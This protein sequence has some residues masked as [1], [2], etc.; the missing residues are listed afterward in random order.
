MNRL[1]PRQLLLAAA[2]ATL[3]GA[4]FAQSTPTRMTWIC[5][6]APSS[7][8]ARRS[9]SPIRSTT[10]TSGVTSTTKAWAATTDSGE[11]ARRP[12]LDLSSPSQPSGALASKE[13]NR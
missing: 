11:P 9:R 12:H 7:I 1:D 2:L 8:P 13:G 6:G 10:G 3:A 5:R 4:A